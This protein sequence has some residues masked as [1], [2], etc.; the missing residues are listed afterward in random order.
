MH[1]SIGEGPPLASLLASLSVAEELLF[2]S[3]DDELSMRRDEA[4]D[5]DEEE[6]EIKCPR[7]CSPFSSCG[8]RRFVGLVTSLLLAAASAQ[9]LVRAA[10]AGDDEGA[11]MSLSMCTSIVA[12]LLRYHLRH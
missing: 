5:D 1:R 11:A 8:L 9:L 6:E 3:G 7:C 10:A 12:E 2:S 4:K